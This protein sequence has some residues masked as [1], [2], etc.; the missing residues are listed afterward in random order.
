MTGLK[1]FAEEYAHARELIWNGMKIRVLPLERIYKS[2]HDSGRDKDI[3]HL[4]LLKQVMRAQK[5]AGIS[6]QGLR[7]KR[8]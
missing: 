8:K 5:M 1:R 2:K 7:Q 3:A 6:D 4:P